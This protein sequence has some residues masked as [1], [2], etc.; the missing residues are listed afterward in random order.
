MGLCVHDVTKP[1]VFT[2]IQQDVSAAKMSQECFHLHDNTLRALPKLFPSMLSSQTCFI[3]LPCLGFWNTR[4]I[5]GGTCR[6]SRIFPFFDHRAENERCF[7][8]ET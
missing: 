3:V 6:K 5:R 7:W 4:V 1:L 2:R 8:L